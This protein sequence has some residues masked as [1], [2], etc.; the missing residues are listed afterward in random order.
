VS[1]LGRAPPLLLLPQQA[2]GAALRASL[3]DA[4]VGAAA[5]R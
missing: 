5:R 3:R 2:A 4:A 1:H